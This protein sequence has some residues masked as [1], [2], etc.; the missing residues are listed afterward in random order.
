MILSTLPN[1]RSP[2]TGCPTKKQSASR[3]LRPLSA[4]LMLQLRRR[5]IRRLTRCRGNLG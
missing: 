1:P 5:L 4:L 2:E 3:E